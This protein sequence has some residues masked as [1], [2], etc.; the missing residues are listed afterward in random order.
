MVCAVIRGARLS[1]VG[2]DGGEV[3]KLV[4][5]SLVGHNSRGSRRSTRFLTTS[6]FSY[7]FEL[8][9]LTNTGNYP[10]VGYVEVIHHL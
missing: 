4:R 10:V 6:F 8:K 7:H 1:G 2:S 5:G 9:I 3:I